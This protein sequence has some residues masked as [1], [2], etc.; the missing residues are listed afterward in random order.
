MAWITVFACCRRRAFGA[1]D[2][3][4]DPSGGGLKVGGHGHSAQ[5]TR[6]IPQQ[7]GLR[8]WVNGQKMF[9]FDDIC[10]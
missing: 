5:L 1:P 10:F 6:G 8:H 7:M 4:D 9:E 3:G 2:S